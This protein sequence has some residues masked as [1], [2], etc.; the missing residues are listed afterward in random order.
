M[1]SSLCLLLLISTIDGQD[2]KYSIVASKVLRPSTVY[3]VLVSIPSQE[4]DGATIMASISRDGVSISFNEA[5]LHPS[6]SQPI[7]LK[8][9][10][11][12]SG[13]LAQYVL[14]VEGHRLQGGLIFERVAHLDF[15]REFLSM[16][17]S[18]SRVIYNG[19][20]TMR[21]RA[22]C[23][24]T[25]L[26]PFEGIVDLFILD[27]DGY[28]IRKWNSKE[29]NVG[30]LMESFTLPDYPKVGFWT[31]RVVAEGQVEELRVKV[32]KWYLPQAFELFALMPSFVLDTDEVIEASVEGA[33]I[34]ER[35]AKGDIDVDW[36]AKKV[37]F[38][39]PMFNDTVLFRHVSSCF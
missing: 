34:T 23:L 29:L 1:I 31:I 12:N 7:L 24:T 37:D 11:D 16:T 32:E 19:G 13:K 20:Q 27:P 35:I 38:Y 26:K 15:R 21:I 36:Y 39:T 18:T 28:V 25:D 9:P 10:S 3:Q 17:I 8:I 4:Q 14:R 6:Q 30:V 5:I 33:F 2:L 22:L